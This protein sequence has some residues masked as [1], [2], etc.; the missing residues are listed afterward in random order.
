MLLVAID[1]HDCFQIKFFQDFLRLWI[2]SKSG[3]GLH[4]IFL[5]SIC[6]CIWCDHSFSLNNCI[7]VI[8]I[9]VQIQRVF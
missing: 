1:S 4:C 3:I 7:S 9:G 6:D 5:F 8:I 2:L